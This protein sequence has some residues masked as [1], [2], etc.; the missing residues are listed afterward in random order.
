VRPV[1]YLTI[2]EAANTLRVSERTVRRWIAR[3]ALE[4]RRV[5]GTVRVPRE[6]LKPSRLATVRPRRGR[7]RKVARV[8]AFTTLAEEVFA[9]TWDNAED[10][11]YDRWREIYGVRQG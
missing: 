10:A 4:A 9:G 6:T 2:E 8:T 3:G 1:E 11:A 7:P 5:A